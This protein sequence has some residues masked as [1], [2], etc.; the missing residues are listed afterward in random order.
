VDA[1]WHQWSENHIANH[2]VA[3]NE[4]QEALL[5]P[6]VRE[7]NGD[8]ELVLGTT[9]AGR[10]LAVVVVPDEDAP[11]VFVV[12]ARDMTDTERRRYRRRRGKG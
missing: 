4:V 9:F 8:S 1:R 2:G 11:T 5:P 7:D 3:W 10:H 6:L 12:T